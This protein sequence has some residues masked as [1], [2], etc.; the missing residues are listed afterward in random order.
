MVNNLAKLAIENGGSITPILIPSELTGGTGLCNPSINIID[1]E[2]KLNLRHVQ[3]TLYH[4]EG[5][6]KFPNQW[7]PLAYLNPE[8]DLTLT[9]RN[10]L[11]NLDPNTLNVESFTK[12]DTSKL[13][14]KPIWEFVGLEDARL[15]KW[16]GREFLCGVRRDT[17]PNGEGRMELSEIVN[18]KEIARYRIQPPG[19]YTY[20]EKNWMP[21]ND[22]PFH[23][24]KWSNPT[25]VVKVDLETLSSKTITLSKTKI[26]LPRDLRGGS[27]VIKYED[28]YIALTHEVDLF[29]NEPGQKDAQYYHRFIVWDKDWNIINTTDEFK[30]FNAAVEFSCGMVIHNNN[31]LISIGFQ[32]NTS[33]IVQLPLQFFNQFLN[34][35]G[36]STSDKSIQ[37]PTPKLV[38]DF[39][40]NIL[41]PINNF[42]LGEFY[43]KKGHTS[44]ALSLFLRAAEF[45]V[46][47]NLTYESLIKVAKCLSIQGERSHSEKSAF[48]NA[49]IFQPTRPEAYFFLSQY[50]ESR[51]DW[52]SANIYSNLA[53]SFIDNLKPTQTDIGIEGKYVFI[54][55]KAV[56]SWWVGQGKLSRELFFDLA[57]NYKNELSER[58]RNLIQQNITSLGSGPDPFLRY[59]SLNHSQLKNKFPGSEDIIKNHSQT[60][61]DMFVLTALN[62]KKNGTYV[63]IGAA[64]PYYGSNSALLE[65]HFNWS[66]ISIEI[67]EDE[68]NKFKE[69]R[70]NPIYLGDA[71]KINYSKFF[72]EYKLGNK[73]DYL[74]LDCEPPS[75]TY[76]ILTMMPFDE[77]KF[78]VITFEHDYY[79]DTTEKYRDLSREYLTSKGYELV[80]SNISPNDDCPYEDWWVHPDLVDKNIIKK[81]KSIDSTTK[82]AEKYMLSL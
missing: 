19:E 26:D 35:G 70:S 42:N 48:E 31:L 28:Y 71:T 17:T 72:K 56:T 36:L 38:E 51:N 69:Q 82:N 53:F 46:D 2:L 57:H 60:Y 20:C 61:Q 65:E 64:D 21:I 52:F 1:G 43:F 49:I 29:F 39:V 73:I 78:A 9:T 32:D 23:F 27:Q 14:V 44:S 66:G 41:D 33:Y 67:L 15:V 79:A 6:Q 68:V 13:D 24:V 54:F 25:E 45:G 50:Y 47:D 63:E 37:L 7:G 77:Y 74:Q 10:Y 40:L 81:L 4:S 3:Y 5:E 75:T 76:D 30:F 62:G 22:M 55:Q 80:V 11:C 12:V 58:Y 8:D 18:G 16:E 34:G 59:T